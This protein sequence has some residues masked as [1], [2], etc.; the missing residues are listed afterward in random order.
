MIEARFQAGTVGLNVASSP[1]TGPP[2]VLL[3]G[4]TRRWQDWLVAVPYLTARWQV[5]ALDFRGHGLSDRTPG[6]YRIADH[7]PDIVAFLRHGLREPAI[8]IGHSLGGNVALAAAAEAP[9]RVRALVLEDPPLEMAGPRLAETPFLDTFRVFER[10]AGSARSVPAIAADLAAARVLIPGRREPVRLGD[11]RDPIS[12]RFTAASLRRLD[13]EALRVPI[14]GRWLDGS[15]LKCDASSGCLP[16]A[17]SPGRFRR[18][19]RLARRSR[20]RDG[21][22]DPGLHAS[23]AGRPRPHAACDRDRDH[24]AAGG[25]VSQRARLKV[26]EKGL[27]R[28]LPPRASVGSKHWVAGPGFPGSGL[29]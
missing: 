14:A 16:D 10:H 13:P 25:G 6:A 1:A 22:S 8:L 26:F 4:V 2:V 3:H 7:V 19:W 18:R 15:D 11:I 9:E 24:D 20:D 21:R 5:F 27:V 23:E 17:V 12:I 29:S 28:G